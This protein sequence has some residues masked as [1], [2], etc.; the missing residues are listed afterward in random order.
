[1]RSFKIIGKIALFLAIIVA[2][3]GVLNYF[4]Y[5]YT[6]TRIDVHNIETGAYDDIFVG[7][8]HGKAAINPNVIDHNT[9]RRSVNVCM[10]GEYPIDAYYIV[11]EATRIHKPSRVIYELD[12]GYW[13]TKANEDTSYASVY[14]EMPISKVK[15][16]Y[17]ISKISESDFRNTL[18]PWYM[19]RK[20]YKKAF[21]IAKMKQ[22]D[23]YKNY[24]TTPLASDEQTYEGTG[25]M[26]I[27]RND[28]PKTETN[29]SLWDAENINADSIKYFEKLMDFCADE[30][31]EL[32]VITAPIPNETYEKYEAEFRAANAYFNDYFADTGILYFDFNEEPLPGFD[33][34]IEGFSDYEGHMY[35]DNADKFSALLC[36]YLKP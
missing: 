24:D 26:N 34:S 28:L 1:M 16:E 35:G 6:Y 23:E 3:N 10:G 20:D 14:H 17:F 4:I 11:K 22:S 31:I 30:G 19:Y 32:I 27:H 36:E 33:R 5:P 12:P 21:E 8:S 7:S 9:G 18:F 15:A 2:V 13:V 29:L 25:F